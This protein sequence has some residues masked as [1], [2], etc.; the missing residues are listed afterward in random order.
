M[1]QVMRWLGTALGVL[2][3]LLIVTYAVVYFLSERTLRRVYQIPTVAMSIPSDPAS[4]A[5]GKRLATIHGCAGG[6]HGRGFEGAVMF[7]DPMVGRI[8]AP[9]L[10]AAVRN[11]NDSQL[12]NIIR[13]GLR[14]DGRSMMVMPSEAFAYLSDE[15]LGRIIAYLKS[16][17]AVEGPGPSVSMGPLGRVGLATGKFQPV[18]ELIASTVPPPE[19]TSDEGKYGRYLAR[20]TCAGCHGTNL[21]GDSNPEFTSPSLRVAAAYS[22]QA[23]TELMRTGAAIGGRTLATMGPWARTHLSLQ[24][25]AEIAALHS[26][27]H[28]MP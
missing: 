28:T 3:A 4:I 24:T 12:V 21:H 13:H 10:T 5:E 23:F 17:P 14:P 11:Y 25:D 15:D 6:C 8:V 26:Y 16:V 20:T 18:A 2:V 1:K 9:N 22:P 27:L 19:A 7:D